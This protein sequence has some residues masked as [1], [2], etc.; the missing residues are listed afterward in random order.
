MRW[1]CIFELQDNSSDIKSL[2]SDLKRT[3]ISDIWR[4]QSDMNEIH[5]PNMILKWGVRINMKWSHSPF[6]VYRV[7]FILIESNYFYEPIFA[8]VLSVSF[9]LLTLL[10]VTTMMEGFNKFRRRKIVIAN[11]ITSSLQIWL[12]KSQ[13]KKNQK[14][15]D[16][17]DVDHF[18]S[19]KVVRIEIS[20]IENLIQ[21]MSGYL[22]SIS[23][24]SILLLLKK[25]IINKK[26]LNQ[27]CSKLSKLL[28]IG[29][30]S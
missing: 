22:P 26:Y 1:S 28:K 11:S 6:M 8:S 30:I 10:I 2:I 17:E 20:C 13:H 25:L 5:L 15:I 18:S 16:F 23:S 27:D 12:N 21:K 4:L 9:S 19:T 29:S 7:V 3:F 14:A 24:M